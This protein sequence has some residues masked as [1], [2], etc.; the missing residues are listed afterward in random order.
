VTN[1]GYLQLVAL[2]P[3]VTYGFMPP[4]MC[5]AAREARET[6]IIKRL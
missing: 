6:A 3:N 2:S 1:L 4:T 5:N